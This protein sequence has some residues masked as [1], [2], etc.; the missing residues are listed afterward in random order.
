MK[1]ACFD[2]QDLGGQR[3]RKRAIDRYGQ[4]QI[5]DDAVQRRQ[6]EEIYV[7]SSISRQHVIKKAAH[8]VFVY[9]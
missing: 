7:V 9:A 2:E 3:R 6:D 4:V 8:A 5:N 1:D